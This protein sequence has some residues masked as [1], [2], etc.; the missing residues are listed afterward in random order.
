M[1]SKGWPASFISFQRAEISIPRQG[2]RQLMAAVTHYI[3]EAQAGVALRLR[4]H[5]RGTAQTTDRQPCG[6][7]VPARIRSAYLSGGVTRS[8]WREYRYMR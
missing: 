2:W 4:Q 7:A 3:V 1:A 5:F 6:P 8:I